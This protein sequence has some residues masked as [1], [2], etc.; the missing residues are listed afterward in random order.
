MTTPEEENI[1]N[2]RKFY[3]DYMDFISYKLQKES[4]KKDNIPLFSGIVAKNTWVY[5]GYSTKKTF[6]YQARNPL[7]YFLIIN[8]FNLTEDDF[9]KN[10]ASYPFTLFNNKH[11][12]PETVT[13]YASI[14][15]KKLPEFIKN[16]IL[17]NGVFYKPVKTNN[18]SEKTT[19]NRFICSLKYDC[20]NK[21]VH[22]IDFN[23]LYN[24]IDNLLPITKEEDKIF[25]PNNFKGRDFDKSDENIKKGQEMKFLLDFG[26]Q[27]DRAF[28][29]FGNDSIQDHKDFVLD[30][31]NFNNLNI[32]E[33][34]R[35]TF[36][37]FG[38]K[39][40]LTAIEKYVQKIKYYPEFKKWQSENR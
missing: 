39:Y 9:S 21:I 37:K 3:F 4:T 12:R 30:C 34:Q 1:E 8:Y 20:N 26:I 10:F 16:K 6:N 29:E 28:K 38:I 14:P 27:L 36:D 2:K 5:I 17:K 40:D 13:K 33:I 15:L 18:T 11:Y 7:G 22:H 23:S 35:T 25:H 31:Y 19:L 24:H 32:E